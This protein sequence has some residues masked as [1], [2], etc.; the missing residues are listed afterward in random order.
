MSQNIS[1][2]QEYI[3]DLAEKDK[4]TS[5]A[6]KEI[7]KA[8]RQGL[9]EAESDL[10]LTKK[11][12]QVRELLSNTPSQESW[13]L[14]MKCIHEQEAS[15]VTINDIEYI[16]AHTDNWSN[17]LKTPPEWMLN[18]TKEGEGNPPITIL[19]IR[20]VTINNT[21]KLEQLIKFTNLTEVNL[22]NYPNITQEQIKKIKKVLPNKQLILPDYIYYRNTE[23]V[24]NDL[25]AFA[26]NEDI[27]DMELNDR[28]LSKEITSQN[29]EKIRFQTYIQRLS[30]VL[31]LKL[32]WP[33][34][35]AILRAGNI[36]E[37]LMNK[38][39]FTNQEAVRSD[40]E[41]VAELA[42]ETKLL[43]LPRKG[44]NIK[45][46]ASNLE[47]IT[48]RIYCQRAQNLL[49]TCSLRETLHKLIHIA[50]LNN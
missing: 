48:F 47:P 38:T 50:G 35:S 32:N 2:Y 1:K 14:I 18:L 43:S 23:M 11:W 33:I 41:Q 42:R 20:A 16:E 49:G 30:Q 34:V 12:A 5:Q 3:D 4:S 46:I 19:L 13:S 8:L 39:Y 36:S 45:L 10:M 29:G 21:E 17:S 15:L 37:K 22:K 31:N 27:E 7:S 6:R 25:K 44:L 28:I 24:K 40:L 9:A 26:E